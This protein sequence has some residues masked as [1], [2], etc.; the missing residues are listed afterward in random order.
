MEITSKGILYDVRPFTDGHV[1]W[2][3]VKEVRLVPYTP[4]G[5]GMYSGARYGKVY[6]MSGTHGLQLTKKNGQ[7]ILLGTEKPELLKK[8]LEKLRKM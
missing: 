4:M 3:E 1:M 6:N 7:K 5:I 2:S 8:V